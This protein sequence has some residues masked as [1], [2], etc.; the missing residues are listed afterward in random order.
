MGLTAYL[1]GELVDLKRAGA[2][3]GPRVIEI[4][5]HQLSNL[6]LRADAELDELYRLCGTSRVT[7]G[8][9]ADKDAPGGMEMIRPASPLSAPFWQSLGFTYT[10]FEYEGRY[11]V[12]AFDLNRDALPPE[13]RGAFD[14]LIN[15]GTT[16]HVF[17][18][19]HA[20]RTIHDLM[21]PN[22][23]M[24]HTGPSHGWALHGFYQ[25]GLKFFW[26]LCAANDYEILRLQLIPWR[27]RA[28]PAQVR[29]SNERWG[30]PRYPSIPDELLEIAY[31]AVLRKQHDRDFVIPLDI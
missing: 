26:N 5:A 29:E 28:V 4:G 20:F 3:A 15:A 30:S 27:S 10:A 16:E 21:A 8:S 2:I 9:E 25:Y 11:G 17:D 22:G 24:I 18:Q 19:D 13:M 12:T 31:M 23:I 7:L 1:L 14:L 6:F